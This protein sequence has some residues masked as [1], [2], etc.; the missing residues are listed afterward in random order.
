MKSCQRGLFFRYYTRIATLCVLLTIGTLFLAACGGSTP[1][2]PSGPVTLNVWTDTGRI[3]ASVITAFEQ[4]HSNIKI[5]L[6]AVDRS[7]FPT[8]VL[9]FNRTGSGW[10]DVYFSDVSQVPELADA[11]H[12]FP[13]NLTSYVSKD[14]LNNFATGSLAACTVNGKLDCLRN[15]LSHQIGSRG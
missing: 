13:G 14:I 10:P 7:Q 8:K 15:D 6:T 4:S 3:P 2:Q 9:L 11:A 1:A 12:H 5:K